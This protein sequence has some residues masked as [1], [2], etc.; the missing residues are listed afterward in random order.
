VNAYLIGQS[1]LKTFF[2]TFVVF[3]FNFP[4]G[5]KSWLTA[6]DFGLLWRMPDLSPYQFTLSFSIKSF[7]VCDTW[8][9]TAG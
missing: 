1:H 9:I 6:I 4:I 3:I 8:L 7:M 2:L 5:N